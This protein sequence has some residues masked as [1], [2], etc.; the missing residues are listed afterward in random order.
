MKF[1][2]FNASVLKSIKELKVMRMVGRLFEAIE[3]DYAV[4]A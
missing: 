3:E 4:S 1:S 2:F